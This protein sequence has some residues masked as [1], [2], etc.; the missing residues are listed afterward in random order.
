MIQ[1]TVAVTGASF[2]LADLYPVRRYRRHAF[3]APPPLVSDPAVRFARLDIPLVEERLNVGPL[4]T[5][6]DP[7][8]RP[9]WAQVFSTVEN[10][11]AQI[12]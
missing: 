2:R 5:G 3:A 7:S 10:E 9:F 1:S 4:Q 11:R 12:T 6:C 8:Q